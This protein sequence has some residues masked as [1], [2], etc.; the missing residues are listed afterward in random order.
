ME[1]SYHQAKR[2][3]A[4]IKSHIHFIFFLVGARITIK[5]HSLSQSL[6]P[7][8]Q[9]TTYICEFIGQPTASTTSSNDVHPTPILN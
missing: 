5:L 1:S 2:Q 6:L 8:T 4:L 9:Y 7:L 3:K